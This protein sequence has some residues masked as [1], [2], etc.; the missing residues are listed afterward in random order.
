MNQVNFLKAIS[1]ETRLNI[2]MLVAAHKELCVCDLTEKLNLSQPKISRHLAL[3]RSAQL[4]S[5]RRQGQ[6]VYYSLHRDLPVWS[7]QLI[8]ILKNYEPFNAFGQRTDINK[9]CCES[10]NV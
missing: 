6:W 5:D 7:V 8:E 1:D 9:N 10:S 2:M 3:L 4:L